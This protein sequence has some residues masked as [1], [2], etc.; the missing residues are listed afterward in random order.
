MQ[1]AGLGAVLCRNLRNCIMLF[2]AVGRGHLTPPEHCLIACYKFVACHAIFVGG[3]VPDAPDRPNSDCP[4]VGNI[5]VGRPA[6]WP[7][8]GGCGKFDYGIYTTR[9]RNG[10]CA[11]K[12]VSEANRD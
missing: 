2:L 12:R 8:D 11:R 6:L 7:P 1:G 9:L 3:G 4:F 5:P 10:H